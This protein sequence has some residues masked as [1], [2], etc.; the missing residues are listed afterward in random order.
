MNKINETVFEFSSG[1][2]VPEKFFQRRFELIPRTKEHAD[3]VLA[4]G[5]GCAAAVKG[6]RCD[7]SAKTHMWREVERFDGEDG[8]PVPKPVYKCARCGASTSETLTDVVQTD[9]SVQ[10]WCSDCV[11]EAAMKCVDCGKTIS[12]WESGPKGPLCADCLGKTMTKCPKCGRW[13]PNETAKKW[14]S[15][16]DPHGRD[17]IWCDFC[18]SE[19]TFVCPKCGNRHDTVLRVLVSTENSRVYWCHTCAQNHTHQCQ[20]CG[21]PTTIS[22][23]IGTRQIWICQGCIESGAAA[24]IRSYHGFDPARLT[25]WGGKKGDPASLFMGFELEAGGTSSAKRRKAAM[26]LSAIDP[27]EVRYHIEKDSSIPEYGF[28]VV[29]APHTLEAHKAYDWAAVLK[30]MVAHN[31]LS[32][33]LDSACGLHVHVSRAFLPNSA[34]HAKLDIFIMN[35]QTFWE[36]IARRTTRYHA[37]YYEKSLTDAGRNSGNRYQAVN[38]CPRETIEFRLFRGSL[39]IETLMG[40]LGLVDAVCRWIKT[41]KA[42]DLLTDRD[43][44]LKMVEWMKLDQARYGDALAYIAKRD[45]L[46]TRGEV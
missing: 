44:P 35:N 4:G 6:M 20:Y 29:S 10:Q 24:N 34:D 42:A 25:F 33:N 23:T 19:Y 26:E 16:K 3:C 18:M 12:S 43:A 36:R 22:N 2:D 13:H 11:S 39:K 41:Q 14:K 27:E 30:V 32:H 1:D 45:A 40:T 9:G 7:K 38:F 8:K 37:A 21:S 31:M 46:D 28:E 5:P 15:Y 17:V